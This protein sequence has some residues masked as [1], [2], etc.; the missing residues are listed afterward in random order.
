LQVPIVTRVI[1]ETVAT[2]PPPPP[3]IIPQHKKE[4]SRVIITEIPY[5]VVERHTID[6]NTEAPITTEY[7]TQT[8][9]MPSVTTTVKKVETETI[10]DQNHLAI[11]S[12]LSKRIG[13]NSR[14]I[15]YRTAEASIP[16]VE[17]IEASMRRS[18]SRASRVIREEIRVHPPDASAAIVQEIREMGSTSYAPMMIGG[19]RLQ[20]STLN[21]LNN[22][23][24]RGSRVHFKLDT[25][26]TPVTTY[27]KEYVENS[28]EPTTLV[29]HVIDHRVRVI[30]PTESI[31]TVRVTETVPSRV[32]RVT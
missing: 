11:D 28:V 12:T 24:S 10:G 29:D 25:P 19:T 30:E 1:N 20:E 31:S 23:K 21:I 27:V 18:T 7:I 8:S 2:P 26:N 13:R 16:E 17:E 3:I 6:I 9:L 15:E 4:R 32:S 22:S 14:L 5:P